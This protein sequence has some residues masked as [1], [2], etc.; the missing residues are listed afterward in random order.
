MLAND[1]GLSSKIYLH[2]PEVPAGLVLLLSAFFL[3]SR[4]CFSLLLVSSGLTLF[5]LNS[6]TKY[7]DEKLLFCFCCV[8]TITTVY[9]SKQEWLSLSVFWNRSF[10]GEL[11]LRKYF[12]LFYQQ[13]ARS[14]LLQGH[15][16]SNGNLFFIMYFPLIRHRSSGA[17]WASF[18]LQEKV[19]QD[20]NQCWLSQGISPA[21]R[22]VPTHAF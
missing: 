20:T 4:L 7:P 10:L 15:M 18:E 2:L 14:L 19:L 17:L 12:P 5:M 3:L 21:P 11:S 9:M 13:Q 22:K 1:T 16:M 8:L 6:F